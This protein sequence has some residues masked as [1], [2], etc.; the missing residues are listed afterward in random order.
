MVG[1]GILMAGQAGRREASRRRAQQS[2][3]A[4]TSD[5]AQA[6]A[7][8]ENDRARA[9]RA[10]QEE[11]DA[12]RAA[13][14]DEDRNRKRHA[15]EQETDAERAAR[16][17]ADRNSK[18]HARKQE[19]NPV[20]T[21]RRANDRERIAA[22]RAAQPPVPMEQQPL[23]LDVG[24]SLARLYA[25]ARPIDGMGHAI[26]THAGSERVTRRRH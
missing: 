25:T 13:R 15:R 11:T 19:T 1:V 2:R 9:R 21:A 5:P 12:D 14:R 23:G 10:L 17:A 7:C 16:R 6:A 24:V 26:H 3:L 18:H 8:R 22:T 4:V 20:R